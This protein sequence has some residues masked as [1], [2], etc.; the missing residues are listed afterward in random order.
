[1]AA[2]WVGTLPAL[3]AVILGARSLAPRFR[4]A[5]PVAAGLLLIATGLYTATGRAAADLS[6]MVPVND[7]GE[8]S[9]QKLPCCEP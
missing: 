9:E 8:L 4:S 5:V 1:M 3:T 2:F 7:V 6:S